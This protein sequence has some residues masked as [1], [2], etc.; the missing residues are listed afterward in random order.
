MTANEV[1]EEIRRMP[2]E[3]QA[4]VLEFARQCAA[5][6]LT[7]E[8]LGEMAKR[9]A[10]TKDSQEADRLEEEIVRG[11]YGGQKHA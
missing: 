10:M 8:D 4:K 6:S 2:K 1:I 7:P 11:F 3:E 9:M 5:R